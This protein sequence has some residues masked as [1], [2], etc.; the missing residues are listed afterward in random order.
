MRNK[1]TANNPYLH[2]RRN[3]CANNRLR[4]G[5]LV[6]VQDKDSFHLGAIFL[7]GLMLRLKIVCTKICSPELKR[8]YGYGS[9]FSY[10]IVELTGSHTEGA[11]DTNRGGTMCQ[12]GKERRQFYCL[13]VPHT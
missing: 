8:P 11:I 13:C 2:A 9:I 10:I 6:V 3:L 5:N 7:N 1:V 12:L 4:G